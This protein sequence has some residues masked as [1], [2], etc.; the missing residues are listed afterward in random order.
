MGNSES[1]LHGSIS[2]R[3]KES[4]MESNMIQLLVSVT[5]GSFGIIAALGCCWGLYK[6]ANNNSSYFLCM[7]ILST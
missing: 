3:T 6:N 4:L 5:E 7:T 1:K 2:V